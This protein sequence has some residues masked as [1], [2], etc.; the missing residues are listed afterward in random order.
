LPAATCYVLALQASKATPQ[1]TSAAAQ[2]G[3]HKAKPK[4]YADLPT[5][6]LKTMCK[7]RGLSIKGQRAQLLQ[8]LAQHKA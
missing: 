2:D 3:T 5:S 8:R 6:E 7:Q 1:A 4:S